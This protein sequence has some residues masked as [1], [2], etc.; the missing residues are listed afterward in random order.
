[1]S[2]FILKIPIV[3]ALLLCTS[4]HGIAAVVISPSVLPNTPAGDLHKKTEPLSIVL[5]VKKMVLQHGK[6]QLVDANNALPG[7][8]LEYRVEYKNTGAT[9]LSEILATLPLPD[10][11]TFIMGSA[12]PDGVAI[13]KKSAPDVFAPLPQKIPSEISTPVSSADAYAALR[14]TIEK[15]KPGQMSVFGMRVRVDG[16]RKKGVPPAS[17]G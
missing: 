12:Y 10:H 4:L 1:L 7:D 11:T 16:L 13:S 2:G 5:T 6:E 15:L 9:A 14:W 8:V 3:A 17:A